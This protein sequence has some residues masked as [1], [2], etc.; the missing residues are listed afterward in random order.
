MLLSLSLSLALA[1]IGVSRHYFFASWLF[2]AT[3]STRFSFL[4]PGFLQWGIQV[5]FASNQ[6][7]SIF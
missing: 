3:T 5:F 2:P 7:S 4:V 1:R 6:R